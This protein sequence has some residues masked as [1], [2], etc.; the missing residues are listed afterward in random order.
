M[1]KLLY[2]FTIAATILLNILVF[3]QAEE[4]QVSLQSFVDKNKITIGDPVTYTIT[5]DAPPST[6]VGFPEKKSELGQWTVQDVQNKQDPKTSRQQLVYT[7]TTF[8]TGQISIPEVAFTY[9]TP[10]GETKE[11][12]TGPVAVTVES[13]LAKYGEANDIR[14]IKP[15]FGVR[16]PLS[17]YLLWLLVVGGLGAGLYFWY[18]NFKKRHG[19]VPAA[20]AVPPRPPLE[21]ALEELEKLK[22]SALVKE[23]RIKEFYTALTDIVRNYIAPV[24]DIETRDRTTYEIYVQLR[25]NV[26]DKKTVT[27]MKEFFDECD[28]VK[29]AKYQP[30]ETACW[31]DWETAKKIVEG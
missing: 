30:D 23:G 14:D 15:P 28:L 9:K 20:P 21:V 31:Q 6:T 18:A 2:I 13:M 27:L 7:L 12:K 17:T 10:A 25:Q 8:T 16:V 26:S 1:K 11:I 22:N 24:Y 5:L 29:F 4:T 3:V 19:I